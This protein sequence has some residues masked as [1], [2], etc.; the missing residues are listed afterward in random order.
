MIEELTGVMCMLGDVSKTHQVLTIE[1]T[2]ICGCFIGQ[3]PHILY[4]ILGILQGKKVLLIIRN[5]R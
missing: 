4:V 2:V 5:F 3:V 1:T